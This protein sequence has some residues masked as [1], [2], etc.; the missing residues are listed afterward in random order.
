MRILYLDLDSMRPDHLGCYGYARN[1]S[2]NIDAIAATGVRFTDCYCS[3]APCLPSRTALF[4]GRFG[5][6]TGVVGHGG[7]A[8]DL[9]PEG[10]SRGFKSNH[11]RSSWMKI[12]ADC[13]GMH[14]VTISSFA[15]RH[16]AWH[17]HAGFN[18]VHN[19]GKTGR[20]R[21]D[22][23]TPI[24]IDWL[25]RKARNDQ[26]FL[27]VNFWDAHMPYRT[28]EAYGNPFS[29]D[30]PPTWLTGEALAAQRQS[31]GP[32]SAR[33]PWGWN[34]GKADAQPHLPGEIATLADYRAWIDG[35][36]TAVRYMDDHVGRLLEVLEAEGVLDDTA[37]IIGSDHGENLGELNVYG[38]HQTAD[39]CTCRIPLIIRWPGLSPGIDHALHYHLDLTPT[40]VDLLSG[41]VPE[42]WDGKS[43]AAPL[44]EGRSIGRDFLV[45]S[46]C[47]W[48]CQRAVRFEEW[49][50]IKTYHDAFMNIA[51]IMLFDVEAD[52]HE[53]CDLAPE[54]PDIVARGSSLLDRWHAHMMKSP[55]VHTDPMQTVMAEGGPYH[56]KGKLEEYCRRLEATG[57]RWAA[58]KL[59][60]T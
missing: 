9:P 29:D 38:N 36:D 58:E 53:S 45:L 47:A 44:R 16:S 41:P 21:A 43:Y 13:C 55:D 15:E 12:L 22:E 8:A 24:A 57:R 40:V 4:S 17:F 50:M 23:V 20:E 33:E 7:T 18:E 56:P 54:R 60:D 49:L 37:I 3:D 34:L 30:N 42:T 25:R 19:S 28:P 35:Y 14:T 10:E 48:T 52:P 2:P 1:T 39:L 51:P 31:Y 32:C 6:H 59:R 27:H 46:Q 5:I 11:G 26:W